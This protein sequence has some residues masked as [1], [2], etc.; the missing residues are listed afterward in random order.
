MRVGGKPVLH[1]YV[2]KDVWPEWTDARW[3]IRRTN[4]FLWSSRQPLDGG[5]GYGADPNLPGIKAT[6][7][8]TTA[9]SSKASTIGIRHKATS[10]AGTERLPPT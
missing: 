3:T 7:R 1:W 9:N 4:H 10:T 6:S 2:E 5:W 8:P